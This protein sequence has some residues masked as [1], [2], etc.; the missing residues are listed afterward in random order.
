MKEQP[1]S[2]TANVLVIIGWPTDAA[3]INK[4]HRN[5]VAV[6]IKSLIKS[7]TKTFRVLAGRDAI[8]P[9]LLLL[10]PIHLERAHSRGCRNGSRIII[11]KLRLHETA[12]SK[13]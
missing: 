10:Q 8:V 3:G 1:F 12:E 6:V 2:G 5:C 4:G 11:L 7:S 13:R 9:I